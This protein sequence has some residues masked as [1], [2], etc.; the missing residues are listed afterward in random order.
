MDIFTKSNLS[1]ENDET[2]K[3]ES[4]DDS[5]NGIPNDLPQKYRMDSIN[6]RKTL[7]LCDEVIPEEDDVEEG[8]IDSPQNHQQVVD[9]ATTQEEDYKD[10]TSIR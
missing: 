7:N 10:N 1:T 4:Q 9:P 6:E 5:I 2:S 3:D 8:V